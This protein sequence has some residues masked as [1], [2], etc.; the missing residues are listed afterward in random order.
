[1]FAPSQIRD[2]NFHRLRGSLDFRRAAVLDAITHAVEPRTTRQLAARMGRDVLSIRPRVTEL[3]Q[4][5]L[6]VCTGRD[7]GEGLYRAATQAEW[8]AW[9]QAQLSTQMALL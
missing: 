7:D 5:G 3:V 9:Q 6:V 4:V 2:T 8:E 1:M